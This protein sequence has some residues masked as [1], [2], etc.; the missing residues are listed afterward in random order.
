M[1]SIQFNGHVKRLT[2]R[3][4]K[5][6]TMTIETPELT[7]DE[8]SALRD[9]KGHNLTISLVPNEEAVEENIKVDRDANEM[10]PSQE[11]RWK[12][13]KRWEASE[14]LKQK[15]PD[16]QMYYRATMSKIIQQ[17]E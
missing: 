10:T 3:E 11:L 14:V 2:D 9:L 7:N 6:A 8:F 15:Y 17:M 16:K 12:I 13:G 5:S 4:D 1:K